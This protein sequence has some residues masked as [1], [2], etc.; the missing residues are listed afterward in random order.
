MSTDFGV[1][2]TSVKG[3]LPEA[4]ANVIIQDPVNADLL[5]CG[6]DNGTWV[7]LNRGKSWN[8]FNRMLNVSSYDMMVHPRDNELVVGTHGRSVFVAD[9]KPLQSLKDPS[10]AIQA[11][12]A[13]SIRHSERWG[14]KS[15]EWSKANTPSVA[16]PY[17]VGKEGSVTVEISDEKNAVIRR[18]TAAGSVGL[19]TLNWDVKYQPP[20]PPPSKSKGKAATVMA[21]PELK[22]V[23]KGKYKVKFVNGAENSEVTVEVK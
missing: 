18:L 3:D 20:V 1:T 15:F 10:K 7:S 4:V 13:E 19:H 9:V 16:V 6:L 12:A 2:W 14:Q 8:Y 17:Y 21:A 23:Q 11:F 5:Y 22:Y